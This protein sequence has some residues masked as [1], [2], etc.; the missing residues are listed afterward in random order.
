MNKELYEKVI[1]HINSRDFSGEEF[2]LIKELTKNL[3]K[4]EEMILK[5]LLVFNPH[6]RPNC[7]ILLEYPF[8][9][10]YDNKKTNKFASDDF[11]KSD[12]IHELRS[13]INSSSPTEKSVQSKKAS[14][15]VKENKNIYSQRK[16]PK[17]P[18]ENIPEYSEYRREEVIK[19]K[20]VSNWWNLD[21]GNQAAYNRTPEERSHRTAEFNDTYRERNSSRKDLPVANYDLPKAP[22][23]V[24]NSSSKNVSRT[25]P[26]SSQN[27]TKKINIQN[28]ANIAAQYP[29][30]Q[31][32]MQSGAFSSPP[33][34]N[35][36]TVM[37][38]RETN[39]E[40]Q[41]YN[42]SNLPPRHNKEQSSR[43]EYVN[44]NERS[45]RGNSSFRTQVIN[46]AMP[47][48][49]LSVNIEVLKNMRYV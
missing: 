4:N 48:T 25:P 14:S 36:E 31:N 35:M 12:G 44:V 26:V 32:L 43:R 18:K 19:P 21:L 24:L 34:H 2:P 42:R 41:E 49:R 38:S 45:T 29:P 46:Q 23:Q 22:S 8:F 13:I 1:N 17:E 11:E 47:K 9:K 33:G 3:S 28:F 10:G 20:P 16:Q 15:P 37:L 30:P 7:D 6:K 5:S 39:R 27:S 40:Q